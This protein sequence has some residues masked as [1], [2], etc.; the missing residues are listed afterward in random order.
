MKGEN[1]GSFQTNRSLAHMLVELEF[2]PFPMVL[3]VIYDDPR[4][5]Y[6]GAIAEQMQAA[7]A[8][9]TAKNRGDLAALLAKGQT[10]TVSGTAQDPI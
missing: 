6:D 7:R 3:G 2:G 1:R 5:T 8:K 4:P 9:G 10:W